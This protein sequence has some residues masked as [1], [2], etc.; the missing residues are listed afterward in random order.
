MPS[1]NFKLATGGMPNNR[2]PQANLGAAF[3]RGQER[4]RQEKNDEYIE[5]EREKDAQEEAAQH[6]WCNDDSGKMEDDPDRL[7]AFGKLSR[8]PDLIFVDGHGR[9]HPRR[10]GIASHL[11]LWLEKPTIGIGKSR[12]CGSY[13]E[14]GRDRP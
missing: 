8:S 13:E 7:E 14:P 3:A 1:I 11:G 2:P 10:I 4:S 5:D 9:A 6:S 12:L